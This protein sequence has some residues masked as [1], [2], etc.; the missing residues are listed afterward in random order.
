MQ[1]ESYGTNTTKQYSLM[2]TLFLK[3]VEGAT[4]YASDITLSNNYTD[5]VINTPT[6]IIDDSSH[7]SALSAI[8]TNKNHFSLNK[9]SY[10]MCLPCENSSSL[11]WKIDSKKTTYNTISNK[12]KYYHSTFKIKNIPVI[13]IPY[14]SIPAPNIKKASGF[15]TPEVKYS[16]KGGVDI[17]LP[18]FFNLANNYDITATPRLIEKT[19]IIMGLEWRH[20]LLPNLSYNIITHG[21]LPWSNDDNNDNGNDNNDKEFMGSL[22]ANVHYNISK[23]WTSGLQIQ[24]VF[25][26]LFLDRYDLYD[27]DYL[28]NN[29]YLQY[30]SNTS[31]FDI[32]AIK[33]K[34]APFKTNTEESFT[35]LPYLRTSTLKKHHASQSFFELNTD[36]L[37]LSQDS[38][39]KTKRAVIETKWTKR[40]IR[41][42]GHI[43]DLTANF[44]AI[45]HQPKNPEFYYSPSIGIKWHTPFI[46]KDN[47]WTQVIT[48]ITQIIIAPHKSYSTQQLKNSPIKELDYS[49]LFLHNRFTNYNNHESTS[50]IDYGL[51]YSLRNNQK[52]SYYNIFIGQSFQTQPRLNLLSINSLNKKQSNV[53]INTQIITSPY[54]NISNRLELESN[55]FNAVNSETTLTAQI[56]HF[57]FSTTHVLQ[58]NIDK[59]KH[60][61]IHTNMKFN[62]RDKWF[63]GNDL[64]YDLQ[65]K[66]VIENKLHVTYHHTCASIKLYYNQEYIRKDV[67]DHSFGISI[68][69]KPSN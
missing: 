25:N 14:I 7:F 16:S 8:M 65:H 10:T 18:Y 49:N 56:K 27:E 32:R 37:L 9:N 23:N 33:Y 12:I 26:Q 34:S 30:L 22:F 69:L 28:N 17:A 2:A 20:L 45:A 55:H 38:N 41:N 36:V 13:Y 60:E 42:S 29:I 64:Q 1:I 19:G 35:I 31:F 67:I 59:N 40:Y 52:G 21:L 4:F 48:P 3:K 62:L 68:K 24:T 63:I 50:R 54:Y 53:I 51:R 44:I 61:E 57:S 15:L 43:F 58:K 66:T 39:T 47:H 46:K 6:I 5:G 11:L